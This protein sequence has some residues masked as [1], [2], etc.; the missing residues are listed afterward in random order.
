M[1]NFFEGGKL[2]VFKSTVAGDDAVEANCHAESNFFIQVACVVPY[3]R[4]QKRQLY[5]LAVACIGVLVYFFTIV[6]FDY[7]RAIEKNKYLDFDVATITAGDYTVEFDM[8]HESYEYFKKVYYD[9]TC[10]MNEINQF[11][12]YVQEELEDRFTDMPDLGFD[13]V[14]QP[15]IE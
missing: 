15:E 12:Q 6:Y 11:K 13:E 3:D 10:P 5:G 14:E 8:P 2:K 4:M 1:L 9:E 7:I